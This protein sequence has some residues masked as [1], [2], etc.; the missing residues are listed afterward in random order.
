M[1]R[2]G[3]FGCEVDQ[4]LPL[5]NEQ[6][7]TKEIC[8]Q[9]KITMTTLYRAVKRHQLPPK[10]FIRARGEKS[11]TWKG[12]HAD[13]YGPNWEAQRAVCIERDGGV[14]QRCGL[15]REE[16]GRNPDVHHKQKFRSFNGD[17]EKA[18]DL[19]NL[20]C[21]CTG[22][23][24]VV[25]ANSEALP[26]RPD[27]SL[28]CLVMLAKIERRALAVNPFEVA[29]RHKA[30][31]PVLTTRRELNITHATYYRCLKRARAKLRVVPVDRTQMKSLLDA[32][33]SRMEVAVIMKCS[34][35]SVYKW[36]PVHSKIA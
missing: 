7:T 28:K 8:Y 10:P 36:F 17:Y 22:C 29:R 30:G 24:G 32:G 31:E 15:T 6:H 18:N 9:L 27:P 34:Y 35:C 16:T 21:L 25:E 2:K 23:H 11:P 3:Q 1:P 4:L 12:G 19:T 13:Y 26:V 20:I 14:C 5:W 33:H